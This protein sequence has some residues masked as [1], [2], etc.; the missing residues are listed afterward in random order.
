MTRTDRYANVFVDVSWG[1]ETHKKSATTTSGA[2][3]EIK[4]RS[5]SCN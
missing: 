1:V 2:V 3:L 4:W 5:R